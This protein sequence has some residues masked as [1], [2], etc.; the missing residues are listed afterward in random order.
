MNTIGV[1][2][3]SLTAAS[4]ALVAVATGGSLATGSVAGALT[5]APLFT[6]APRTCASFLVNNLQESFGKGIKMP[7]I[8]I[9][10]IALQLLTLY[11]SSLLG[12]GSF[13]LIQSGLCSVICTA[14]L[15]NEITGYQPF[16]ILGKQIDSCIKKMFPPLEIN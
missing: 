6:P 8:V 12:V 3:L 14:L 16:F 9:S 7:V 13:S 15:L 5:L 2:V 10:T 4:T 11:A 1:T